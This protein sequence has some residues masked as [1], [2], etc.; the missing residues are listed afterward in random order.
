MTACRTQRASEQHIKNVL[1]D[2]VLVSRALSIAMDSTVKLDIML[3]RLFPLYCRLGRAR[4][5]R[6]RI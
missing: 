1:S 6:L 4:K 2:K 3:L 5:L